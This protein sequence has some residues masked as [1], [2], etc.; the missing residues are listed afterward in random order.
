MSSFNLFLWWI[1]HDVS[2]INK[3][4]DMK[5]SVNEDKLGYPIISK[6]EI[7]PCP[8]RTEVQQGVGKIHQLP[9]Q[10][11]HGLPFTADFHAMRLLRT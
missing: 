6:I 7:V 1:S 8:Q 5:Y 4:N 9:S 3:N 11:I 2:H 10:Y